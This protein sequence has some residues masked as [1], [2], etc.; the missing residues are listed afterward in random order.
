M[1]IVLDFVTILRITHI[2]YYHLPTTL[3][4]GVF[5]CGGAALLLV[6]M[7]LKLL[8]GKVPVSGCGLL[9]SKPT[10]LV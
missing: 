6:A 7:L 3:G 10:T 1:F 4:G 5:H 2:V 8:G 9:G